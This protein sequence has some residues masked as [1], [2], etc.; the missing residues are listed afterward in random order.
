M[1]K[2]LTHFSFAK[3]MA[4]LLIV[5]SASVA[6]S[7]C[8]DDDKDEP[9][10][11]ADITGTWYWIDEEDGEIDYDDYFKFNKNGSFSCSDDYYGQGSYDYSDNYLTL[12]YNYGENERLYVPASD[13]KKNKIYLDGYGPY[14]RK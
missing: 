10:G 14:I 12:R 4:M 2:A 9:K 3:F 7:S 11:S 1:K 8:K 5:L 6:L 13:V